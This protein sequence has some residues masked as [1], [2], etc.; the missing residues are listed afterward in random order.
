MAELQLHKTIITAFPNSSPRCKE[1]DAGLSLWV[2]IS[3][4]CECVADEAAD[5]LTGLM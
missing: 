3:A 1:A 4:D 5:G 2:G